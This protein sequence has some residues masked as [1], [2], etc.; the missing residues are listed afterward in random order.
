MNVCF[1]V[2]EGCRDA[3]GFQQN[4]EPDWVD[5]KLVKEGQRLY[6]SKLGSVFVALNAALMQGFTIA[7][8]ADVLKDSGY[9]DSPRKSFDRYS[10]TGWAIVDWY[11]HDL[12]DPQ[13]RARQSIYRVRC[14]HTCARLKS[15]K[16]FDSVNEGVAVSQYDLAEVQM[17]FSIICY[18]IMETELGATPL[19]TAEK[20]AMLHCWRLIGYHLGILDEYNTCTS[21]PVAEALCEEYLLWTPA[22]LTTCRESTHELQRLCCEG[23]GKFTPL[24][25]NYYKGFLCS[26][27]KARFWNLPYVRIEPLQGVTKAV[28]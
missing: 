12:H 7:R 11:T 15:S 23:L 9:S 16:L 14:M 18:S 20:K 1:L 13:S 5:W 22:R 8:F 27:Q 2:C 26:L 10:D 6:S 28:R 24:G 3:S 21:L 4:E 17:G 25:V 19:S